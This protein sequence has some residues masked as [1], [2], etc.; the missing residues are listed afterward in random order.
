MTSKL[1][2][3]G[4]CSSHHLQGTGAYHG[5]LTTGRISLLEQLYSV[6]FAPKNA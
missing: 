2:A 5:G 1:T 6:V 4:G 3:M